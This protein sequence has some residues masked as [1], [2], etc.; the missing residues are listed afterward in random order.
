[1]IV[2]T[3]NSKGK[4]IVMVRAMVN[5]WPIMSNYDVESHPMLPCWSHSDEK[6][7]HHDNNLFSLRDR[8]GIPLEDCEWTGNSISVSEDL[9][10]KGY[11]YQLWVNGIACVD[12]K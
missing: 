7:E 1:M 10:G 3:V 8:D 6:S 2:V 4:D 9:C 11:G 5:K 12:L